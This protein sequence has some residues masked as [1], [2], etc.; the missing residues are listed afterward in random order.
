MKFDFEAEYYSRTGSIAADGIQRL[1]GNPGMDRLETVIRES[2]QNSWDAAL[3]GCIP[4]YRVSVRKF[5]GQHSE[6]MRDVVFADPDMGRHGLGGLQE[7]LGKSGMTVMEIADYGTGGLGGPT[8]PSV[9]PPNDKDTDFVDFLRNIGTPRDTVFGG[10]TYGYGKSSL[11]TASRCRTIL[12][13]SVTTYEGRR[14]RRL[15]ACHTGHRYDVKKGPDTGRFT[16]RHWWGRSVDGAL[17]PVTGDQA[18]ELAD[19]LGLPGRSLEDTGTTV[20]ILDPELPD[21]S[22][23]KLGAQLLGLLLSNVWPKMVPEEDGRVP[24]LFSLELNGRRVSVPAPADVPPL[25]LYVQALNSVR[26]G[27]QGEIRSRRP[28]KLLGHLAYRPGLRESRVSEVEWPPSYPLADQ[29]H[30]IALM[31]PAELVVKYLPG[32]V[33]SSEKVEWGGVFLV[34]E[35]DHEVESAFA[36][37][38]P[39]AHDDWVPANM[40]KGRKRTMVNVGLREINKAISSFGSRKDPD[41]GTGSGT[42][43]AGVADRLGSAL[44]KG[45]GDRLGGGAF[46]P[47][48]RRPK[49]AGGGRRTKG[50]IDVRFMG[51]ERQQEQP[52]SRYEIEC[53]AT[54]GGFRLRAVPEVLLDDR[55]GTASAPN[56]QVPRLNGWY[57]EEGS[58]VSHTDTLAVPATGGRFELLVGIPDLV[59]VRLKAVRLKD[60][61]DDI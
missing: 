22:D 60:E 9:I 42:P 15:I 47:V 48:Q 14:V 45:P 35:R 7:A 26:M 11:F 57:D 46:R 18:A 40:E 25:G 33:L 34:N 3:P 2:V 12:V 53:G 50:R 5:E 38:E 17:H 37:S 52:F 61:S 8:D 44:L 29:S 58:C 21:V 30:H 19:I 51:L 6:L 16:G 13:D 23:D 31:R 55:T 54:T 27:D 32:A 10:G 1:L 24:M 56:G 41:P 4:E 36:L 43:L 20:M 39:P 28:N 59:A 49:G